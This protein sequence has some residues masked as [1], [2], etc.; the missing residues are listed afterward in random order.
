[1]ETIWL[2]TEKGGIALD[3]SFQVTGSKGVGDL[4]MVPGSFTLW[5]EEGHE[6]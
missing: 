4:D 2:L 3:D 1:V 6:A 5:T